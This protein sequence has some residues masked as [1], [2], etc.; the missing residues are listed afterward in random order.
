VQ[1]DGKDVL[2]I[3]SHENDQWLVALIA[4]NNTISYHLYDSNGKVV[5]EIP[6]K[7]MSDFRK[8]VEGKIE[9]LFGIVTA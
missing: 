1:I 4:E 8:E 7:V 3:Q 6:K 5:S 9:N 2:D